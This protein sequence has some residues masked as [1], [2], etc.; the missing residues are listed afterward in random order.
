[1]TGRAIK[2]LLF[3]E[4]PE[5]SSAL[6]EA[7]RVAGFSNVGVH[8]QMSDLF[9]VVTRINP[10]VVLIDVASPSRDALE[11][12]VLMRE[13]QPRPVVMFTQDQKVQTIH[14]AIRSGVSAYVTEEISAAQVKPAIEV[15]M[16]IFSQFQS[17][18]TELETARVNLEQRKLVDRAKARLIREHRFTED[19][20]YHFLRR[21]AMNRKKR[22]ID[23]AQ[24]VV[25]CA[26]L[27][28]GWV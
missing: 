8:E 12:L 14:A 25:S 4:S 26:D 19:Q 22:L 17:L 2:I 13:Q 24:E 9:E 21:A 28:G 20:A 15:A 7:L 1:M 23:V 27:K 16:E 3:D 5:R 18:R 11:Q 10:D 6:R